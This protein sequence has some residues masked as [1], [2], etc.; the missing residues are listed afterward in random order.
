MNGCEYDIVL[1]RLTFRRLRWSMKLTNPL[2]DL[3]DVLLFG[4]PRVWVV[5]FNQYVRLTATPSNL[6]KGN[7]PWMICPMCERRCQTLWCR[8]D[9]QFAA[10]RKCAKVR[11]ASQ[12]LKIRNFKEY[13]VRF[14]QRERNRTASA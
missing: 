13:I 11:Y 2:Q 3:Q 12:N 10:C 4:E 9:W 14:M 8:D 6:G 1:M 5:H 7:R